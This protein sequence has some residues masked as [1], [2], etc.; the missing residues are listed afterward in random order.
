MFR[1]IPAAV[2]AL[3]ITVSGVA[4]DSRATFQEIYAGLDAAVSAKD[5]EAISRLIAADAQI[6]V[7]PVK[8]SL[9]G[10]IAGEMAKAGLSRRSNVR[11]VQVEGDSARVVA[12]ILY[13]VESGGKKQ[14]SRRIA[15]DTWERSG[16]GWICRESEQTEGESMVPPTSAAEAKPVIEELKTRAVKLATVEPPTAERDGGFDDLEAFGKAVAGA[17]IVALGEATHGTRE[18]F[19]LK[20]RLIEYLVQRKGFSVVAFEMNWP[21]ADEVDRF[22]KTPDAP[23]P[24]LGFAE[25]MDWMRSENRAGA[26]LTSTGF[27]MQGAGPAADLVMQYLRRVSPNA[28]GVATQAYAGA[29]KFDEDHTNVF[30]AGAAEAARRAESVLAQ[31]DANKTEWVG[32]SSPAEWRDARHAA[33]TAVDAAAMRVEGNGPTYRDR[34]MARNVE[35]L[36]DEKYPGQKLILWAHNGHVASDGDQMGGWLRKRFG[37]AYYVVGTAYRWGEI[38]AYGV[39]GNQ[40]RGFGAWPVAPAPEGSGDAVLSGAG[41]PLFFLDVR[42]VLPEGPLGG[43][44]AARHRFNLAG[45][46]VMIGK[47]NMVT[48]VVR[49]AYD[50]LMFV[51]ESHAARPSR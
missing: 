13:I 49:G 44:L 28:A 40:N 14:E 45:G 30:L 34:A 6:H 4:Q 23:R 10:L 2:A 25:L 46:V 33:E 5:R 42:S 32:K 15:R 41:I 1:F 31:F 27:D 17:R 19:L 12:D 51:E 37:E 9:R 50:G 7:G 20:Q 39:E 43:W 16:A 26:R 8:L 22:I 47:E 38:W 18:F 24:R 11:S 29:R 3:A 36:A 21:D 35:W 48:V